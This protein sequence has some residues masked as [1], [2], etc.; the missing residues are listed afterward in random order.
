MFADDTLLYNSDSNDIFS[1]PAQ[2]GLHQ[3]SDWC[4]LWSLNLNIDKCES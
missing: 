2:Q 4:G 3:M 1:T